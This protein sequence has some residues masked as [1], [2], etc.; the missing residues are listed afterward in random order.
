MRCREGGAGD[1]SMKARKWD[2]KKYMGVELSG[3]TLGVLGLGRLNIEPV[4]AADCMARADF[5]TVHVPLLDDTKLKFRSENSNAFSHGDQKM[6][7]SEAPPEAGRRTPAT[8][9][10]LSN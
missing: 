1:A 7:T 9:L 10:Q 6:S 4:S 5:L 8:Q 2:R 3:K